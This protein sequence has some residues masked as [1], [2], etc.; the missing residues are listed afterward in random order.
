MIKKLLYEN[1]IES[2]LGRSK[3]PQEACSGAP[4][5]RMW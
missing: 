4:M 5:R 1:L 2:S 3:L